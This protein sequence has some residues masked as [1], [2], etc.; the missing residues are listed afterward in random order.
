MN[1]NYYTFGRRQNKMQIKSN[2]PI[3]MTVVGV[4]A[5]IYGVVNLVI[6]QIKPEVEPI[7]TI[8]V[9]KNVPSASELNLSA[10]LVDYNPNKDAQKKDEED[11]KK[12]D[13]KKDETVA[14]E[15]GESAEVLGAQARSET[16]LKVLTPMFGM[17]AAKSTQQNSSSSSNGQSNEAVQQPEDQSTTDERE[18]ESDNQL[19]E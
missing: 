3:I 15:Q 2:L 19:G 18:V 16:L 11:K 1:K 17:M 6:S 12:K 4:I 9:T 10:P 13:E 14:N 5:L 7:S 8:T